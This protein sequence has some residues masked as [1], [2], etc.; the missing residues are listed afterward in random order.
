MR[1]DN[2]MLYPKINTLWK[3]DPD[4]K[5]CIIEGAFSCLDFVSVKRW[6]ITEKIDGEQIRILWDRKQARFLGK[7]D[8]SVIRPQ[9]VPYLTEKFTN[10]FFNANFGGYSAVALFT[11]GYGASIQKGGELYRN[12]VG[13]IIYDIFAISDSELENA[14]YAL[15]NKKPDKES[16]EKWLDQSTIHVASYRLDVPR[17]PIISEEMSLEQSIEYVKSKPRSTEANEERPIEGIVARPAFGERT[18]F[19]DD[20]TP[21]M[22]KL[23]VK[24]YEQLERMK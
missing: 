5:F 10:E 14:I 24:D 19:F 11:E 12:D 15:S 17:V 4:N 21:I 13:V 2:K 7:K 1:K 3:R 18:R 8:T 20:G 22:W 16:N 23:K 6:H 9:L